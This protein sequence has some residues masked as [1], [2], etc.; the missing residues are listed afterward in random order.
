MNER[1][2][3]EKLANIRIFCNSINWIF[4]DK[5]MHKHRVNCYNHTTNNHIDSGDRNSH[6]TNQPRS[7]PS[8]NHLGTDKPHNHSNVNNLARS[9][10]K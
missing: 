10:F 8:I 6:S 9:I 3:Y 5:R 1:G 4:T 2:S 7:F